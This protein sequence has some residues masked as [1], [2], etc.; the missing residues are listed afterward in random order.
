M[1]KEVNQM[2][3]LPEE[4]QGP[5][6]APDFDIPRVVTAGKKSVEETMGGARRAEGVSVLFELRTAATVSVSSGPR[7]Q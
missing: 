5:P 3:Q 2:A 6:K 1:Q 4:R 7:P